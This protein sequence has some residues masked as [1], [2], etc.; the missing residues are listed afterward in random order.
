VDGTPRV[1][2]LAAPGAKPVASFGAGLVNVEVPPR[3][4]MLLKLAPKALGGYS[5]YK[6]VP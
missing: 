4:V 1:D 3:T 2:L 5:R 6:R